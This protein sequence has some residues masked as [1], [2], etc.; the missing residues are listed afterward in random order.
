M[1]ATKGWFLCR[2]G[3]IALLCVLVAP[4]S[5]LAQTARKP[6][7]STSKAP[8]STA[9]AK[10]PSELPKNKPIRLAQ[11]DQAPNLPSQDTDFE[12]NDRRPTSGDP[13]QKIMQ[14]ASLTREE[15]RER[16][17]APL[18]R[19]VTVYVPKLVTE[20]QNVTRTIMTPVTSHELRPVWSPGQGRWLTYQQTGSTVWAPRPEVVAMDVPVWKYVAETRYIDEPIAQRSYYTPI[21]TAPPVSAWAWKQPSSNGAGAQPL[22]P[23]YQPPSRPMLSFLK[24]RPLVGRL[25]GGN[26]PV[27]SP[28]PVPVGPVAANYQPVSLYTPSWSG[29]NFVPSTSGTGIPSFT[30]PPLPTTGASGAFGG[31]R[32]YQ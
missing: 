30:A 18:K 26:R 9:P 25:F 19:S 8:V 6:A 21:Q 32:S 15:V 24:S 4:V 16:Q 17:S 7:P 10:R 3:S 27:F 29:S 5:S 2:G 22:I 13:N 14:V 23:P 31:V 28:P 20:R 11:R 1:L 12:P